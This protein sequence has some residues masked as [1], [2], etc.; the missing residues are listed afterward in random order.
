MD[1]LTL[2]HADRVVDLLLR[3]LFKADFDKCCNWINYNKNTRNYTDEMLLASFQVIKPPVL[4][5]L[6]K[7]FDVIDNEAGRQNFR[8]LVYQCVIDYDAQDT[9]FVIL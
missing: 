8:S 3:N 1:K 5:C 4:F 7:D 9:D 6:D 2:F